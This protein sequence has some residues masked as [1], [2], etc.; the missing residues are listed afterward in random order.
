VMEEES[1]SDHRYIYFVFERSIS[2]V[3]QNKKKKY[4]RWAYKKMDEEKYK[5]ALIWQNINHSWVGDVDKKVEWLQNTLTDACNYSMPVVTSTQRKSTYWW[6]DV[7]FNLRK[8]C[9]I[10][11]RKWQ[12]AKRK[13]IINN[14]LEKEDEYRL[15]K[16][17]L[18]TE[19]KRAKIRAW[20]EL[21][22]SID[23]NPWGLAYRIVLKKLRR[24]NLSFRETIPLDT[25]EQLVHKLFPSDLNW[26][27]GAEVENF[28]DIWLEEYDVSDEEVVNILRKKAG[29]NKAPGIDGIK[30]IFLKKI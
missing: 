25:L 8:A 5:E 22:K 18:C 27:E 29:T 17:S 14:I 19:L 26:H 11:R 1:L 20:N 24:S 28:E 3:S 2:L 23:D 9:N 15:A 12:K 6:S 30:S 4:I 16:K 7:I 21:I 13:G 10:A